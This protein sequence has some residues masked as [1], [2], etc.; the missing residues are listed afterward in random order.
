MIEYNKAIMSSEVENL[1]NQAESFNEEYIGY[2]KVH[3]DYY[4]NPEE[5]DSYI[6]DYYKKGMGLHQGMLKASLHFVNIQRKN[7]QY[8]NLM[9]EV[10]FTMQFEGNKVEYILSDGSK[11]TLFK[12]ERLVYSFNKTH[13]KLEITYHTIEEMIQSETKLQEA[14]KRLVYIS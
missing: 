4:V 5:F 7:N 8:C 1:K 13:E 6:F 14:L 12:V 2:L 9:H 10:T 3:T 11:V